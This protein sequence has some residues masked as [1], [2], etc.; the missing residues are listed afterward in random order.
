MPI[1]I[2]RRLTKWISL[3]VILCLLGNM[4]PPAVHAAPLPPSPDYTENLLKVSSTLEKDSGG[5]LSFPH[6][7]SLPGS[8]QALVLPLVEKV[9]P[10]AGLNFPS[11]F[12]SDVS[13]ISGQNSR[14]STTSKAQVP[15]ALIPRSAISIFPTPLHL[16]ISGYSGLTALHNQ[17]AITS[18]FL[19][20]V[21]RDGPPSSVVGEKAIFELILPTAQV[22]SSQLG[23]SNEQVGLVQAVIDAEKVAIAVLDAEAAGI[24][25][26]ESKT[27]TEKQTAITAIDYNG[28]LKTILASSQTGLKNQLSETAYTKLVEWLNQQWQLFVAQRNAIRST[29]SSP[30]TISTNALT[31]TCQVFDLFATR[32]TY[33]DYSADLP[34]KYVKFA[35]RGLEY[36][37]GYTHTIIYSITVKYDTT[38]V[39]N[40]VVTDVVWNHNDNYWN[41]ITDTVHPRRMFT[42][43]PHGMPEAE[44]AFYDNYNGG[45]NEFGQEVTNPAGLNVSQ[46][47]ADLLGIGG[48]AWIEV[49][50]PWNCLPS[51]QVTQSRI[52]RSWG[53]NAWSQ[54]V[55]QL[56][57]PVTGNQFSW[58]RDLHVPAPGIAIDFV[59]YYNSQDG[60]DGIFGRGWS[61]QFDMRV[62]PQADGSYKVRYEDGQRGVFRPDGS[63]SFVGDEGVFDTFVVEGNDFVLTTIERLTYRFDNGGRL[64]NIRDQVG[65]QVS[66]SYSNGNP[67]QIIDPVGRQ[68]DLTFDS[69]GHVTQLK[70][71]TGR[72]VTYTYGAVTVSPAIVGPAEVNGQTISAMA[73]SAPLTGVTDPNG[74][75]TSYTYDPT[76]QALAQAT[77]A[78][79]ISFVQNLYDAQGRVREQRNAEG[80]AGSIEYDLAN[81][82]STY[83]DLLG[84][85]TTYVFDKKFRVIEEIDALGYSIKYKY[86]DQDN[87]IEKTDKRGDTWK[88]QYDRQGNM[89][90]REDPIDAYSAVYYNSDVTTWEY[91][92]RNQVTKMT[93]ALGEATAY[94]YDPQGNL[95]KATEPNNAVTTSVFN[96][97]GQMI[98]MTDAEGRVTFFEY[99]AYGNRNKITDPKGGITSIT[100]DAVGRVLARTDAENNTIRYE[101]DGNGNV[102]KI[103]DALGQATLREY[104]GSNLVVKQIDRRGGV[105]ELK[106]DQNLN[107]KETKDPLGHL[108]RYEYDAMANRTKM[109]EP[110]GNVT[111]YEYDPLYHI[112]KMTDPAGYVTRYE[113]DKNGNIAT[114]IDALEG[115]TRFVYDALN[116]RKFLYDALNHETEFCYD[117]LDRVIH[118]FTPRRAVT[119]YEYDRVGNLKRTIDPLGAITGIKYDLVHNRTS[120]TDPNGYITT[121]IYDD[122]NRLVSEIDPLNHS[123]Q[124][125]YDKVGNTTAITDANG[126]LNTFE[127]NANYWLTRSTNA[128]SK[129]TVFAYDPEGSQLSL[130]DELGRLSLTAYDLLGRATATTDQLGST[131]RYQYDANGNQVAVADANGNI[132]RYEYDIRNLLVKEIDPLGNATIYEYDGLKRL[133]RMIDANGKATTYAYDAASQLIAVADA[134]GQIYE[135][136]YD[137]A[138]NQAM[139]VDSNHIATRF[140]YNLRNELVKEI[141]PLTRTWAYHYDPAGNMIMKEDGK[142]QAIRY[143][144]D[145][146]NRLVRTNYPD[147]KAVVYE[148]DSNGNQTRMLDWNGVFSETYDA[149][150]RRTATT[151]YKGRQLSYTY[152][153]ASNLNSLIYPD[154]KRVTYN[155]NARYQLETMTDPAGLVTRYTYDPVGLLTSQ[156]RPNNTRTDLAYDQANRL[157]HLSNTGP[158]E[159]VVAGFDFTLDPIGNRVKLVETRSG[160][161]PVTY[162]FGYD[163]IYQLIKVT[164]DHGQATE[165]GYDSAGNRTQVQGALKPTPSLST[166]TSISVTYDYDDLNAM[167]RADDAIFSYDANGN[168]T[169]AIQPLAS[170]KYAATDL[171]GVL[172][173]EYFFDIENRLVTARET[174][175]YTKRTAGKIVPTAAVVMKADYSY[176]GMGRRVAK[177]VQEYNLSGKVL[178]ALLRE[179]VYNGL[180]VVAEY[181]YVNG[182]LAPDV[183]HYYY[184]NGEKVAME[185]LSQRGPARKYWYAY[186]ALNSTAALLDQNGLVVAEYHHDEFGRLILGDSLINRYLFT[187]QEYDPETGL[188]H[189]FARYY[190]SETG[191]WLSQD[192]ERGDKMS[193]ATL[194]RYMYVSN[195]PVNLTDP[196][197]Y[198][199]LSDLWK[200]GT[201]LASNIWNEAKD[202]ASDSVE[203]VDEN[204]VKPTVETVKDAAE[205]VNKTIVQPVVNTISE[206]KEWV[207]DNIVQPV[208]EKSKE[209]ISQVNE[210]YIQPAIEK[211]KDTIQST[212]EAMTKAADWI[213]DHKM[214]VAA[215]VGF[216]AGLAVG[217]VAAGVF[218]AAT[219]GIGC[220]IIAG[221]AAG[222]LAGGIAAGG[223]QMFANAF[224][225]SASTGLFDNVLQAVAV[226]GIAGGIGGGIGGALQFA[227][228]GGAGNLQQ[229]GRIK[230][231]QTLAR[232]GLTKN[233]QVVKGMVNGKPVNTIPDALT[234][235]SMHEMKY[236]QQLS[237]TSQLRAQMNYA[238]RKGLDYILHTRPNTIISKPL[239]NQIRRIGGQ[240]I[241]DMW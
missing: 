171:N 11:Y 120:L 129:S 118:T 54:Y 12:H 25:N 38:I 174:I 150:N 115:E 230:E 58:F 50:F 77:D 33:T 13:F 103:I 213:Q 216:V 37:K 163:D 192:V 40:V 135:Y 23:F 238:S 18:T 92:E 188:I 143:D 198:W 70:D 57:N 201:D 39:P 226:G 121:Y 21:M 167:L 173:S 154:G 48:S 217:F 194:H 187:G 159:V 203:W 1:Q 20:I 197:G 186:D 96:S 224:D 228:S 162:D 235:T 89:I 117:P 100:Y 7:K 59:R 139:I 190:D 31:E 146:A 64:K 219:A 166:T 36:A 108:V 240:I 207:N 177:L 29:S 145:P 202:A 205:V 119:S 210:N 164:S 63:G 15:P 206:T 233:N 61:S 214:E 10:L 182:A 72:V 137:T 27:L 80:K 35:N 45:K 168:R 126:N 215:G 223:T 107:L 199:G 106:Y 8:A 142:L 189:F 82:R 169:R 99:D 34:D 133:I 183:N 65:N 153:D 134:K 122:L 104:N 62:Y 200:G 132:S 66:L 113:Y 222:L 44:A 152:D 22:L 105:Y 161:T 111:S 94:E 176:D 147:G 130:T 212:R 160:A 84:H 78:D 178:E 209:I 136:S 102:T 151:D 79:N 85:R 179:Y 3:V 191:V 16:T 30:S 140:D 4:L 75:L 90:R 184:G 97:Q 114:V 101:Y 218:C 43:L 110:N 185:K 26:D 148:Y 220:A 81:L 76:N 170:T 112:T 53:I 196:L 46:Q 98:S 68:F 144:Y 6:P 172:I 195:N 158:D 67:T 239:Q 155:Y 93:N 181:E 73:Q 55:A 227:M 71:P 88:Y 83:T 165:Y 237:R 69:N 41:T 236:V 5:N 56:V 17:I 109:I 231:T 175:S 2:R 125:G 156:I 49:T 204:I 60:A 74:G 51:G 232:N 234:K 123:V 116:R 95:I 157:T 193:P 149:L 52:E 225:S 28:R 14:L 32:S 131:T 211:A 221:A 127:Y 241:K 24:I 208:K 19:P 86:D 138:G 47:V 180:D 42:D 91:N 128:L 141:N 124:T 229:L 87:L 9:N